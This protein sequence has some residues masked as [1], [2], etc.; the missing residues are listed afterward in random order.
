M[1][2]TVIWDPVYN[3]IKIVDNHVNRAVDTVIIKIQH[4]IFHRNSMV[5]LYVEY[6]E[7]AQNI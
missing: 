6:E 3:S 7:T 4:T 1:L 2:Y 5:C